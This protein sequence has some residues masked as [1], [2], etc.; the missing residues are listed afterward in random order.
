MPA[1]IHAFGNDG[2]LTKL[3]FKDIFYSVLDRDC[4]AKAYEVDAYCWAIFMSICEPENRDNLPTFRA[5]NRIFPADKGGEIE[6]IKNNTKSIKTRE[7]IATSMEYSASADD[8]DF[9]GL[10]KQ[11]VS[12]QP[13]MITEQR[14]VERRH[15]EGKCEC[16]G[17]CRCC[18]GYCYDCDTH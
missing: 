1:H 13:T 6:M 18:D 9:I 8:D 15:G 14:R 17:V 10:Y 2:E 3:A 7:R 5:W 11:K 12:S 16:V 4:Q